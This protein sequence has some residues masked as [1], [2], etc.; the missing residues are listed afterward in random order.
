MQRVFVIVGARPN[1]MKVASITDE[2][3]K[4][5]KCFEF[6]LVHTGQH[7]DELMS[8]VF[9][10]DL[11]LPMPQVCLGIGSG[12]H[13][14]Q[15]GKIM[16]AFEKAC[17]KWHPSQVVVVGD[18]NSTLACSITAAKLCIPVAHVEAGLRSFDRAMPEE[19]NRIVT[20]HLS[21]FLFAP[22]DDAVVNLQNEGIPQSRTHLVGNVMIDTLLKF[23]DRALSLRMPEKIGLSPNGYGV[24]TLHRPTNVDK[25]NC[26]EGIIKAL[27][28]IQEI[29]PLVFP[30]HARTRRNLERFG[31]LSGLVKASNLILTEPMGYLNFL[32][33]V[34]SARM[35]L[36]DSGGL[37]EET[38]FLGIPCLTLR[39]NTERPVT[40]FQ[41]TNELVNPEMQA[42]VAK[43]KEV[44]NGRTKKGTVPPLWDGKASER[45]V[46]LLVRELENATD[47]SHS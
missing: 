43:A 41:G 29:L 24:V 32:S 8:D 19:I 3:H 4:Y 31:L 9:F 17:L 14:E 11:D 15:V 40:V 38:T 23:K 30:V 46:S 6:I 42:I 36:T 21:T 7:Y 35:V 18:V 28:Q 33:I 12:S 26:L 2:M 39:E 5:S 22:S 34:C 1:F 10:K 45:I 37:Q 13:A 16:I 20:D 44:L 47:S 25:P 27:C